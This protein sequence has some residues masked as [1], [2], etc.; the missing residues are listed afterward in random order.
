MSK[1]E[2]PPSLGQG[3]GVEG[4]GPGVARSWSEAGLGATGE[5]EMG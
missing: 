5:Q 3:G 4:R 1:S 2:G